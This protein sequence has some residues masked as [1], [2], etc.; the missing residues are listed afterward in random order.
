[1]L[2]RTLGKSGLNV[3]VIAFGAWQ[4]G[5]PEFWGDD[6]QADPDGVVGAAIDAG[7]NLFD[8]AELYGNG[9]SEEV[10]GKALQGRREQVFIA[11]KAATQHCNADDLREACENSLRRLG[12]DRIDLYQVHWPLPH[13]FNEAIIPI[14]ERLRIEGKIREIGVS[15]FGPQDIEAW[16]GSG[17]AVS[18][19]I[20]YNLLFRAPE[21]EM[22]PACRR[23]HLGVLAYMPL[24]QGLLSG[25]YPDLDSIPMKR[26]RS[27]H[28][29]GVREGTRHDEEGYERVLKATL[30]ALLDFSEAIHIPLATVSLAWLISQPGVTSAILGARNVDQLRSNVEAVNLNIGPAAIALLNEYSYELKAVMGYNCDMWETEA[31]KRIH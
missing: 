19:Q 4:I 30:E 24:M 16:M 3:S 21:Y 5:D 14:L 22:I 15:N 23:H 25:R 8:T 31:N 6:P 12:T 26:R 11:S 1:M 29:S 20:G 7:I 28:F 27:R 10:L 13:R 17:T 9:R 18:D 2:Y